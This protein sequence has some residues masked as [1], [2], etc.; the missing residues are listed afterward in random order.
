MTP[1]RIL[2]SVMAVVLLA[3]VGLTSCTSD[4]QAGCPPLALAFLGVLTGPDASSGTTVRNSA[5]MAVAEHNEAN[6]ACEVGFIS[7]DS[8][9]DA[10]VAEV[11]ARQIVSDEQ[12]IAVVGPVFSGETAAVMPIFQDAGLPVLT[13]S[14]TNPT[15]GQQGWTM[16]HRL[17]GT[18]AA[19]GPAAVVWLLDEADVKRVGVVDDG[20]LF[21]KDL[22]D[23]ATDELNRRGITIAPRQQVEP[24]RRDYGDAVEAVSS[25][26]VDA[27]FFGG[28]GEAGSQ[29]HRQLRDAGVGGLFVGG[30]GLYNSSFVEAVVAG[31]DGGVL[32]AVS[33][34][35]AGSASTDAQ[36][37]FAERYQGL[38]N[39]APLYFAFEGFDA[40]AMLLAA[41]DSG[42]RTRSAV[43]QWLNT[44]EFEGVSKTISFDAN[45]EVIG[46]PVFIN[47]IVN[48]AFQT[49]AKV[50]DGQV[51]PVG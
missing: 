35:C 5:A 28:L 38:Y 20:T 6:P 1:R 18:D 22:A 34:P 11:L 43:E 19:Q 7:Y 15:L 31:P 13:P 49:V 4:E 26:G 44:A 2:T 12:I 21:G 45:G 37:A 42:A 17:V 30:D 36:R 24:S 48:G 39:G 40:A 9:G 41:I 51:S 47:R 29:L 27:V 10:D 46:G 50:S 3:A 23:F 32:A 25:V 16:F 33:C 8:Q 14:A